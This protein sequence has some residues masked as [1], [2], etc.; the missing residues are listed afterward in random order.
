MYILY[1]DDDSDLLEIGRLFLEDKGFRVDTANSAHKAL[2]MIEECDY[3]AIIS[4]YQMPVMDGIE[5]FETMLGRPPEKRI[6]FIFYT[7]MGRK[8]M[9][10]EMRRLEPDAYVQ[11]GGDVD[12]QF[13]ELTQAITKAVAQRKTNLALQEAEQRLA[14]LEAIANRDVNDIRMALVGYLELLK[15]NPSDAAKQ[16][17]GIEK[18]TNALTEYLS[19]MATYQSVKKN[20][21]GW[22]Q[23]S[24]AIARHAKNYPDL[25]IVSNVGELR[26]FTVSLLLEKA[27][28]TLLENTKK[29]G[30]RATAITISCEEKDGSFVVVYEDDGVGI[31]PEKKEEIFRHNYGANEG[32]GLFLLREL[33]GAVQMSIVEDGEYGRGA[34]FKILIP[35][36]KCL[37]R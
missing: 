11:K 30:E 19:D 7:G 36:E 21:C 5:F 17:V 34:R 26:I 24:M 29:Y 1:V 31:L 37:L 9:F 4:D 25:N 35:K 14:I 6:P 20:D 15:E 3:E 27:V 10:Y 12:V 18:A 32:L 33:F 13:G 16:L 28:H 8:E 23:F 2:K 22:Q